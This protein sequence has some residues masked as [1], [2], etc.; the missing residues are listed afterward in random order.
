[1]ENQRM[2]ELATGVDDAPVDAS[3]ARKL[4]DEPC[5]VV[6]HDF[7]DA[8]AVIIQRKLAAVELTV[9]MLLVMALLV[10]AR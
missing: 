5:F 2:N 9:G 8:L 3:V 7:S 4:L 6:I 1:M 10:I